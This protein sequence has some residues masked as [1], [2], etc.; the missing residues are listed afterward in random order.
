MNL[1][2][3]FKNLPEVK[4]PLEKR[5][6]FNV[7]LKWTL[8]VLVLFFVLANIPL[9]GLA[10]NSLERF[11]YLA[12]I[13]GT[14]FGSIISLGIGPIVMASIVLQLLLG[15]GLLQ[16]DTRTE[17]GKKYFQGLQK[18]MVFAF[19]IF[20][21]IVYVV[22]KGLE[23]NPGFQA[24]VIFQLVLGGLAIV[25]LDDLV[26]KWGFGSGVSLFIAAGVA[27]RIFTGLFQFVSPQGNCL[28][29]FANTPCAGKF[30][31]IIQSIVNQDAK[32][33]LNAFLVIFVTA[34]IFVI[35]VWAQSL[36][37]EIPLS[38]DR[39]RGYGIRWPLNFFY[40]S[41][42][43]VILTAA[44]IANI[45]LFAG[46]LESWLGH[47]TWLGGFSQGV[48]VSGFVY[49]ISSV[50]LV[51]GIVTGSLMTID[52]FRSITHTLFFVAFAVIFA[53]LWVKTS[54]LDANSQ[55]KNI[56]ASGLQVPGFRRDE[57]VLESILERYITPL[58]IMGGAAI[59]LLAASA[60]LLGALTNGTAILLAVMIFHNFYESIVKQHT[61]DM[62][63]ALRGMIG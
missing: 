14:D 40:T 41:N 5:V 24:I 28:L 59:G 4:K 27:W 36:K 31:V 33:A 54:G 52:I 63:P 39:L 56:L 47:A 1:E 48:P 10:V 37:I 60:D 18:I 20:E 6:S 3:I 15:G 29:D 57:R 23:A 43:P 12:I 17:E 7:K 46:L 38:F 58:T 42:I 50:N 51:S 16:I 61:V 62:H 49:W 19:I 26:T 21:A 13:L 8:V 53:V 11:K 22:M 44:F 9:Y 34:L 35:V 30:L 2:P 25:F 32:Q 55:A 45:Q